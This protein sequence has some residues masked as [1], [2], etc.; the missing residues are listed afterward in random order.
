MSIPIAVKGSQVVQLTRSKESEEMPSPGV[1]V[2]N[3]YTKLERIHEKLWEQP[4]LATAFPV[5]TAIAG[6][7]A[8]GVVAKSGYD[9]YVIIK[10]PQQLLILLVI[11][12]ILPNRLPIQE[13]CT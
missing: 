10:K 3:C 12:V 7:V 11:L 5:G 13:F 2:L 8:V 9:A 6:V 4:L 1:W